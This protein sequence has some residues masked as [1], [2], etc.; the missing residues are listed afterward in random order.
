MDSSVTSS[1]PPRIARACASLSSVIALLGLALS[2]CDGADRPPAPASEGIYAFANG[3]YTIDVARPGQSPRF[4]R[5][6]EGGESFA[7]DGRDAEGAARFHMRATDLGAYLLYDAEGRY[8]S[9]TVNEEGATDFGRPDA[10]LSDVILIDDAYVSPGEWEL[11]ASERETGRYELRHRSTG[12]FLARE[13][14]TDRATRAASITFY[15]SDGCATFPEL[16]LDAEGEVSRTTWED[17]AVFGVADYHSHLFTNF[18]FGGGGIFHGSPFH[19]LGV[20]HAL[21]DCSVYHGDEGRRDLMDFIGGGSISVEDPDALMSIFI[22]GETPEFNHHTDGYPTFTD[23]PNSWG[24]STHQTQYYRWIE[25]AYRGGLRLIVQHATGNSILCDIVTGMGSQEVR[26]SCNDMVSVERQITE[27]RALER[28]IDAQHGGPG[29]GWLRIVETPAEARQVISDGK[30]AIV[31]GIEISNLF[32]CFITPG[33]DDPVCDE[34]HVRQ[35]LDRYRDLGVRVIFPNHKYDNAFTPGDGHRGF[36]EFAN[37]LNSG[38]WSNFTTDCPSAVGF[39]Q[40]DLQLGALNMPRE[41]YDAP[42]VLALRTFPRAPLV[43]FAPFLD[44]L[45][46]GPAEGDY[47]QNA[48]LTPIGE[49]LVERMMDRGMLIDIAHLPRWS[50]HRTFELTDAVGYPVFSTHG[51]TFGG[52]VF[53]NGGLV[54]TGFRRCGNPD[55]PGELVRSITDMAAAVEAEG[56]YP[57]AGLGFDLNGFAGGPRPRF[58]PDSG[59]GATQINPVEYPFTS[60]GGDVMFTAPRLGE[61]DVDF[62]TEGM[63]H[64]GL[65]PELIEDARRDG[66]TDEDLEPLFRSAETYIRTWERAESIA[67]NRQGE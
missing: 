65:L 14:L 18:G 51:A 29:R 39:D 55:Q 1:T 57:A 9:A 44:H 8:F 58:G 37:L 22:A 64:L 40:G 50:Y 28:Y 52:R 45:T 7:I 62:N 25:R 54:Q 11:L 53:T 10:L 17:G 47:C 38:H 4:I 43:A 32:D 41:Q 2:G 13:G 30:L 60:F 3:C 26:Y 6:A 20:E 35:Q 16:T 49:Y 33:A 42:R 12:L 15:P 66:A 59:C 46:A 61:R 5:V 27:A 48:S 23:W 63:I 21:S 67:A 56:G 34:E 24:S 31:L 36:L 19:R